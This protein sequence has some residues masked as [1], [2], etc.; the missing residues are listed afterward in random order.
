MIGILGFLQ[1]GLGQIVVIGLGALALWGSFKYH[2]QNK[3]AARERAK[4]EHAGKI[5]VGKAAEAR[6]AVDAIPDDGLRDKY[7]RD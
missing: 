7:Y 4:I 1:S 5:N 6:R 2:Y 3:G